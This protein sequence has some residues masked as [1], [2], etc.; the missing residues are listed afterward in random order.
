ML[1]Q[2]FDAPAEA[3]NDARD[4]LAQAEGCWLIG[5]ARPSEVPGWSYA[6]L[7]VGEHLLALDNARVRAGFETLLE[8]ARA[9]QA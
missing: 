3:I 5:N 8:R 1:H 2:H 4:A 9:A 7:S 6:E